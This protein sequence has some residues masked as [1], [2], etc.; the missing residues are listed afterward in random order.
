MAKRDKDLNRHLGRHMRELSLRSLPT[1]EV[2][3]ESDGDVAG[4]HNRHDDH[5]KLEHQDS[6][7][8]LWTEE[9]DIDSLS[10]V[11]IHT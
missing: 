4:P 3:P 1:L 11:R 2:E 5:V 6:D 7:S 8:S 10:G 9:S